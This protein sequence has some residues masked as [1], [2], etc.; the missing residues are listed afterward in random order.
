MSERLN[1][2]GNRRG[3]AREVVWNEHRVAYAK[4][5]RGEGA[6]LAD[7]AQEI[8]CTAIAIQNASRIFHI[9]SWPDP[10]A[11]TPQKSAELADRV[12]VVI[13]RDLIASQAVAA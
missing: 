1:V 12:V 10:R 5:R 11:W 13:D 2:A 9:G 4:K 3:V 7:V 6:Y 8:G